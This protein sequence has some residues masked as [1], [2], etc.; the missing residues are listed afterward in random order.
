MRIEAGECPGCGGRLVPVLYGLP[1]LTPQ[2]E[3][4]LDAGDVVLGGCD[5]GAG[6]SEICLSC[7]PPSGTSR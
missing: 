1:M 7:P 4:A 5:P 3:A 6:P 2:L